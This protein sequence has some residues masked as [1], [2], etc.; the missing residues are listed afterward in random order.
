MLIY[1]NYL[2]IYRKHITVLRNWKMCDE[3]SGGKA[4]WRANP[5]GQR[6][7]TCHWEREAWDFWAKNPWSPRASVPPCFKIRKSLVVLGAAKEGEKP[8]FLALSLH[9]PP[10]ALFEQSSLMSFPLILK[11]RFFVLG[12][13]EYARTQ[14]FKSKL[15]ETSLCK[16]KLLRKMKWKT[17]KKDRET[18]SFITAKHQI[19]DLK[20]GRT[21]T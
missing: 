19:S 14:V 21:E 2:C 3:K 20:H 6:R 18:L 13:T 8:L 9:F 17:R 12:G 1:N 15:K 4:L 5:T 11:T 7:G 10:K 16:T